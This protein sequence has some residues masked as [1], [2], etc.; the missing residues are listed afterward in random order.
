[1]EMWIL[2][3]TGFI[4]VVP[5]GLGEASRIEMSALVNSFAMSWPMPQIAM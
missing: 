2:Y 3:G 1:M 5:P 4:V